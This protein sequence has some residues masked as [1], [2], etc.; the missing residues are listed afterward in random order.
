M[1]MRLKTSIAAAILATVGFATAAS[2]SSGSDAPKPPPKHVKATAAQAGTTVYGTSVSVPG[3]RGYGIASAE[4]PPG[5]SPSGGG[6]T[7]SNY[8][9]FFTDS[10]AA[11][12]SW[13]IRGTN[14]GGS[15]QNLTAFAVC[16]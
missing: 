1:T 2:A 16:Q 11:G 14:T 12:N 15:A 3:D 7:T 8:D 6:G 9:I 5:T 10:Y 13:Y 4:C